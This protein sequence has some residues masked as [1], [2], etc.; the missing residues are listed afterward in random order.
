MAALDRY[1]KDFP[2]GQM[3]QEASAL[4]IEVKCRVGLVKQAEVARAAFARRWP[5][6]LHR[7]RVE[8]ACGGEP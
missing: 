4:L 7:A 8:R 1:L 6:S 5:D 3:T 2:A